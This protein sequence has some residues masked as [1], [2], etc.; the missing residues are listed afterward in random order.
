MRGITTHKMS[1]YT[2]FSLSEVPHSALN[3][4]S[5]VFPESQTHD[6]VFVS[7]SWTVQVL[8]NCIV[9]DVFVRK[10]APNKVASC[11]CSTSLV[12]IV[13][14]QWQLKGKVSTPK[15][16]HRVG[17]LRSVQTTGLQVQSW[18]KFEAAVSVTRNSLYLSPSFLS[19]VAAYSSCTRSQCGG[20]KGV[21]SQYKLR[22]A[23]LQFVKLR[24]PIFIS[25]SYFYSMFVLFVYSW[26]CSMINKKM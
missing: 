21:L 12:E 20:R 17:F 1:P 24:H 3:A 22:F 15:P 6:L 26:I 7:T 4:H 25:L 23:S 16:V 13:K 14:V 18:S 9:C 8:C 5:S 10:C 2:T 19:A 11:R